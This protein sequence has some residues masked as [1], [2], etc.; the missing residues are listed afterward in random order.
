MFHR[1]KP[2]GSVAAQL[3]IQLPFATIIA[4]LFIISYLKQRLF[5]LCFAQSSVSL[6]EQRGQAR[7]EGFST[8]LCS[9]CLG[10]RWTARQGSATH[11]TLA[12]CCWEIARVSAILHVTNVSDSARPLHPEVFRP[13]A[14][15]SDTFSAKTSRCKFSF[16]PVWH[17]SAQLRKAG[18]A[19][20]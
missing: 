3:R 18:V 2:V 13:L 9:L 5:K 10:C 1:E 4:N 8:L 7:E 6:I 15:A 14:P 11:L 20:T 12:I 19:T 16:A 17:L